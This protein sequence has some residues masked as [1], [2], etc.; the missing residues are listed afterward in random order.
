VPTGLVTVIT[1]WLKPRAQSTVCTGGAG[2]ARGALIVTV[3][4]AADVHPEALVTVKVYDPDGIPERVA[5]VPE[6]VLTKPSGSLVSVHMPVDGNPLNP[7]LP[8]V[9]AQVG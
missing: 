6:P 5:V 7:T 3:P 9:K 4:V 1:A 2:T 8:V